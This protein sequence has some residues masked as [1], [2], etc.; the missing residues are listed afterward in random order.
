MRVIMTKSRRGSENGIT[1]QLYRQGETYELGDSLANAFMKSKCAR[2]AP[3]PAPKP[4]DPK[5]PDGGDDNKGGKG[6]DEN[7]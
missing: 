5:K 2:P 3:E 4:D 1:V 6:P 7:K